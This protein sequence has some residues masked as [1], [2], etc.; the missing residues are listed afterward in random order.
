[1]GFKGKE[2]A[3]KWEEGYQIKKDNDN[4]V[5]EKEAVQEYNTTN[6]FTEKQ[7]Q[8]LAFIY[9]YTK[10]NK[11]PPELDDFFKIILS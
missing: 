10:I 8:Y 3:V 5:K 7:G 11:K 6:K 4:H 9:Y 1:M 2:V